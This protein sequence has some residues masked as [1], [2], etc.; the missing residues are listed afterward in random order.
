MRSQPN[1]AWGEQHCDQTPD[2]CTA[3]REFADALYR[4]MKE[5]PD[6]AL[7]VTSATTMLLNERLDR[8]GQDEMEVLKSPS[9][10]G[11]SE[12]VGPQTHSGTSRRERMLEG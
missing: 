7:V 8:S 9:S 3:T 11:L 1:S 10:P 2:L 4:W 12:G 6:A 5:Q